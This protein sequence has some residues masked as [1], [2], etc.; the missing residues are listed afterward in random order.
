M[1]TD[2]QA[3]LTC[4]IIYLLRGWI[5]SAG[6]T[7]EFL[8]AKAAGLEVLTE[9]VGPVHI[10]LLQ[11]EIGGWQDR[12][13]QRSEEVAYLGLAEEVGEIMRAVVKREQGIRGTREEWRPQ[14]TRD[15]CIGMTNPADRWTERRLRAA[16]ALLRERAEAGDARAVRTPLLR[17]SYTMSKIITVDTYGFGSP[18][19]KE[20]REYAA[21][22]T[23]ANH[24]ADL[25]VSILRTVADAMERPEPIDI[26]HTP[27]RATVGSLVERRK[28]EDATRGRVAHLTDNDL[29]IRG[30]E[31]EA[32]WWRTAAEQGWHLYFIEAGPDPDAK[33]I[34]A[35][36]IAVKEIGLVASLDDVLHDILDA[37]R[38]ADKRAEQ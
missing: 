11:E 21:D 7:A 34:E 8:A 12:N 19:V 17:R 26:T 33:V 29:G 36:R 31:G 14:G 28:G 5:A 37:V 6:A 4:D 23:A 1:R 25:G 9:P 20:V 15:R 2:M 22:L 32:L 24:G 10:R 13:F 18:S 3:M 35:V 30:H 38:E 27:E 16:A